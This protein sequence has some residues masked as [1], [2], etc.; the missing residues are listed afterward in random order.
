MKTTFTR[1]TI[2]LGP[3]LRSGHLSLPSLRSI[4]MSSPL[5]SLFLLTLLQYR[6][7]PGE[8]NELYPTALSSSP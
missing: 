4:H 1:P 8:I 7:F 3:N 5:C 6:S 2:H